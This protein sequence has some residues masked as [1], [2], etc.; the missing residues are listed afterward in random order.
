MGLLNQIEVFCDEDADVKLFK[1]LKGLSSILNN[2]PDENIAKYPQISAAVNNRT[3][4]KIFPLFAFDRP[5]YIFT[6]AGKPILVV[7]VT[8]HAYTGDNGLQRF[9]RV[10]SAAEN[11]VPFIYFGPIARVRDDELD[12][13]NDVS[14]LSKRSLTSDFFEGMATLH[15]LYKVPMLFTEWITARNGKVKKV[16]LTS[17][18][19]KFMGVYGDLCSLMAAIINLARNGKNG[20]ADSAALLVKSQAQLLDLANIKNTRHSDVK[21]ALNRTKTIELIRNPQQ[22][23]QYMSDYFFKGKPDKL[24]ALYALRNSQLKNILLKDRIV[25]DETEISSFIK[26][27]CSADIFQEGAYVYFSGYKWR[28]DPHCGVAINIYYRECKVNK[29]TLV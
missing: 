17:T 25:S 4:D 20:T 6:L 19:S 18:D 22:I 24:L 9:V 16:P 2:I 26:K 8:E 7:E 13:S 12:L 10:A 11:K 28:S 23:L 14:T 3:Y 5:D 15:T 27:I 1:R 29:L 21:F